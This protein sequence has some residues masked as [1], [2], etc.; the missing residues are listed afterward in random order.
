MQSYP[1]LLSFF[2]RLAQVVVRAES[3]PAPEDWDRL[4]SDLSFRPPHLVSDDE[5]PPESSFRD[6]LSS[7]SGDITA[8][9]A[10]VTV[11]RNFFVTLCL[12]LQASPYTRNS[13]ARGLSSFDPEGV[14]NG[15]KTTQLHSFQELLVVL[16]RNEAVSFSIR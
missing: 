15:S 5:F 1:A 9:V 4:L 7:A 8:Q 3:L 2:H 6:L 14:I 11:C 10:L 13:L 12:N 16:E